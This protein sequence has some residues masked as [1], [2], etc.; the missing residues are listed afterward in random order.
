MDQNSSEFLIEI[1]E[2]IEKVF[3]D[4]D[5]LR[6]NTANQN[7]RHQSIDQ[8]FRHVHSVKGL[9]AAIGLE[10]V[11][12]IAHEFE[13]LLDALRSGSVAVDERVLQISENAVD[14]LAE[15]LGLA[16]SGIVEPSRRALF[17]Q[18]QTA[19]RRGT[20]AL[21]AD[22]DAVLE[23]IPSDIWQSLSEGE[24]QRL[25]S[26]VREGSP[27]FVAAASFDISSFDDDFFRL[28]ETLA[29]S[30]EVIATSPTVDPEHSDRVNFRILYA[31]SASP[32][33][34]QSL[35]ADCAATFTRVE[36]GVALVP[37]VS[38]QRPITSSTKTTSVSA[39][40]NFVR[41]RAQN[42]TR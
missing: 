39:L 11:S 4:L 1:E 31:S 10:A 18:L 41:T 14:A 23:S 32:A 16:A 21:I 7:N 12:H 33:D 3:T 2:L 19:A 9:S 17:D 20:A 34:L 6:E 40:A 5:Q 22:T 30:G 24:K 36:R 8:I 25:V 13:T 27:L 42:F 38:Y 15:S 35:V 26:V 28:R 37:A 29:K